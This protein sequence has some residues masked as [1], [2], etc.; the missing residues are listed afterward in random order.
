MATAD[1]AVLKQK[2]IRT[3]LRDEA[4]QLAG[5]LVNWRVQ[6]FDVL[7]RQGQLSRRLASLRGGEAGA[8]SSLG[9]ALSRPAHDCCG[10]GRPASRLLR[11]W[12]S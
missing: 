9:A 6:L 7:D 1:A 2:E 5:V 11:Y 3:N 10:V 12:G 8:G 4:Q